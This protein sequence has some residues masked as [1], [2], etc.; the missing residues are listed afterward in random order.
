MFFPNSLRTMEEEAVRGGPVG[1]E[2]RKSAQ[3]ASASA[4]PQSDDRTGAEVG[5]TDVPPVVVRDVNAREVMPDA[6]SSSLASVAGPTLASAAAAHALR[7]AADDV[8]EQ[9]IECDPSLVPSAPS[10]LLVAPLVLERA[11][12]EALLDGLS[13]LLETSGAYPGTGP[14]GAEHEPHT[15]AV[16]RDR[17]DP[18]L[19]TFA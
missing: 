17:R 12:V 5:L 19:P 16:G 18:K 7:R 9:L 11:E 14:D 6:A 10:A 4:R 1:T 2:A 8:V 13:P 3:A 15:A